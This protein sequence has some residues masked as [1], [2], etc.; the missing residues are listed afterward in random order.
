MV[1]AWDTAT[2]MVW[3]PLLQPAAA[4]LAAASSVWLAAS[5]PTSRSVCTLVSASSASAVSGPAAV[6][7]CARLELVST[8]VR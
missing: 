1:A 4:A 6:L 5:L 8:K 2:Q 3:V 7:R